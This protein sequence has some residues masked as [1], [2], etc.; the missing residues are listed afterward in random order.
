MVHPTRYLAGAK[1]VAHPYGVIVLDASYVAVKLDRWR[2]TMIRPLV[3][4][5]YSRHYRKTIRHAVR[6]NR[7]G[8]TSLADLFN[9]KMSVWQNSPA[10]F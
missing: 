2:R 10:E 9:D 7:R 3:S 8:K 1:G 6:S 4:R 5:R